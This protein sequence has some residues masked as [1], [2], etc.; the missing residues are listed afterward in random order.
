M[1]NFAVVG[2]GNFG[3]VH[4][5]AARRI[6]DAGLARF[7]AVA[8]IRLA[9]FADEVAELRGRGVV[10]YANHREMLDSH[11]ELDLVTL[12]VPIHLHA[13]MTVVCLERGL[14][15]LVEKPPASTL[16]EARQMAEVARRTGKLC[17]VGF[18]YSTSPLLS[19]IR[20]IIEG[21]RL[22]DITSLSTLCLGKRY[23]NYYARARWAG[24]I[25]VDGKIVRDGTLNNPYAHMAQLLLTVAG[26][27][28]GGPVR[29]IEL[30]AELFAGHDIETEDTC[31]LRAR[32]SSGVPFHFYSSVCTHFPFNMQIRIEGTKG[33]ID[34]KVTGNPQARVRFADGTEEILP[35]L[36]T[37]D[38]GNTPAVFRNYIEALEGRAQLACPIDDT[39]A[40]AELVEKMFT[41][42]SVTHLH[43]TPY[44][45]R[46]ELEDGGRQEV[47]TYLDGI[48]D[49]AVKAFE[50]G[51]LYSEVGAPWAKVKG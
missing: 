8:D 39:L 25:I 9:D 31:A 49:Y 43:D 23:D 24:R 36:I 44:V 14:H 42:H 19:A 45:T 6:A 22:G 15:V 38:G 2:I 21:G 20:Q 48:E 7:I 40:F 27:A 26:I 17:G 10:C 37:D 50:T 4:L 47:A 13:P 28:A 35:N 46:V 1:I 30:E 12:P 5:D 16:A 51:K 29:P 41:E 3:A 33:V 18:Q 11:P 34:W 32:L